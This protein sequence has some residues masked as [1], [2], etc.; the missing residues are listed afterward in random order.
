MHVLYVNSSVYR[1]ALLYRVS[2]ETLSL[3]G[4]KASNWLSYSLMYCMGIEAKPLGKY[5]PT[6]PY[7]QPLY[8]IRESYN[9]SR[10]LRTSCTLISISKLTQWF[11]CH[12]LHTVYVS[13]P[14]NALGFFHGLPP[15]MSADCSWCVGATFI[16]YRRV[17]SACF[18]PSWFSFQVAK[19]AP[20]RV[21]Q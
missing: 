21:S 12:D 13:T 19:G 1:V 15:P 6:C 8:S 3:P 18:S 10:V 5:D 2:F 14:Y 9:I 4:F 16:S 7:Q 20:C 17:S 11:A